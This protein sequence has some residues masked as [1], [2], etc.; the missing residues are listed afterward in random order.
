MDSHLNDQLHKTTTRIK[1]H[2][3][4]LMFYFY[5]TLKVHCG[6]QAIHSRV[7]I[8]HVTNMQSINQS[9]NIY[10][11]KYT[12][13]NI[14]SIEYYIYTMMNHRQVITLFESGRNI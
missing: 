9:I 8:K 5:L 3:F 1:H 12:Y 7:N 4:S 2:F 14:F 10:I 13:V 11:Y 6:S